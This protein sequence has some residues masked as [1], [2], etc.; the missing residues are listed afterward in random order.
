MAQPGTGAYESGGNLDSIAANTKGA[1]ASFTQPANTAGV[2]VGKAT[3]G[4]LWSAVV[5]A[6]GTAGLDIYDNA[7]TNSGT[8]LLSIPANA[9]VGTIYNI[10]NGGPAANGIVSNGVLNCPAVTLYYS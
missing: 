8:K 5:T 1:T 3:P 6:T 2:V 4:R 10:W 9:V 7:S